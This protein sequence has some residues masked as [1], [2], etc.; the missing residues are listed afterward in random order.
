MMIRRNRFYGATELMKMNA[1]RFVVHRPNI[2]S[3]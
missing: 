1:E 3:P 2:M